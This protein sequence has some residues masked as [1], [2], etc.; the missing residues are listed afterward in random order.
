MF[1]S[2]A[3]R[4]VVLS[5]LGLLG[6]S[7]QFDGPCCPRGLDGKCLAV[8]PSN[9]QRLL[10]QLSAPECEQ[11][12]CV[13]D[14]ASAD[15]GATTGY[16]SIFCRADQTCPAGS[17]GALRCDSTV[18]TADGGSLAVCVRSPTVPPR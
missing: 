8:A 2:H 1:L 10:I 7:T 3:M 11:Q 14:L 17:Q 13:T 12:L 18:P 5:L 16:C 15:G 6:C 4:P 9:T